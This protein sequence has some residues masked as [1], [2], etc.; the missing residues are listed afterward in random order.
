MQ[1]GSH[2]TK[3]HPLSFLCEASAIR[4]ILVGEAK[5][6][7]PPDGITSPL[8]LKEREEG[9]HKRKRIIRQRTY[10]YQ[11]LPSCVA[12]FHQDVPTPRAC[13]MLYRV[14]L[15]GRCLT[16][17]IITNNKI[18]RNATQDSN[19]SITRVRRHPHIGRIIL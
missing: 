1:W 15:A 14:C 10:P 13:Y 6:I 17:A 3:V 8:P 19:F 12:T 16:F 9:K 2:L 4:V 11:L 5:E 7:Q 18:A